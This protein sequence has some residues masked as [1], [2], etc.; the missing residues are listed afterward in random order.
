[1]LSENDPNKEM[2]L[3]VAPV[4][5]TALVCS[6]GPETMIARDHAASNCSSGLKKENDWSWELFFKTDFKQ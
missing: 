4:L 6:D 2:N 1:M 5:T 3:S